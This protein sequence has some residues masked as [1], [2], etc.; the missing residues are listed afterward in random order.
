MTVACGRCRTVRDEREWGAL[1]ALHRIEREELSR[2]LA[3]R[4]GV[5]PPS[6]VVVRACSCGAPIARFERDASIPHGRHA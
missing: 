1:P 3:E 2:T 6:A 5:A 4:S